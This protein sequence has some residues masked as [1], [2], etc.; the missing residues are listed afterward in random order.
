MAVCGPVRTAKQWSK[1][2]RF[3]TFYKKPSVQEI[4]ELMAVRW[5]VTPKDIFSPDGFFS[6][7]E[8]N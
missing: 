3:Q 7:P 4:N 5:M 1:L 8:R 2:L 6:N